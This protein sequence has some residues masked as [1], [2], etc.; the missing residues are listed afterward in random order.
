MQCPRFLQE[1][2]TMNKQLLLFFLKAI[3]SRELFTIPHYFPSFSSEF[4][5]KNLFLSTKIANMVCS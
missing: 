4:K 5:L 2:Q 3:H 1:L